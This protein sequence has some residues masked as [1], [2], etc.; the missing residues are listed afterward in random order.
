[1]VQKVKSEKEKKREVSGRKS[2][3]RKSLGDLSYVKSRVSKRVR[4]E[5][6]RLKKEKKVLI[7]PTRIRN[8]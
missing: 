4:K 8:S 3:L 2:Q 7:L 1:V 5:S 6:L